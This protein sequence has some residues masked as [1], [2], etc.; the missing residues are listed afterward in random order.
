MSIWVSSFFS[1]EFSSSYVCCLASLSDSAFLTFASSSVSCF[2]LVN[3]S[4]TSFLVR[5]CLSENSAFWSANFSER[6]CWSVISLFS[7]IWSDHSRRPFDRASSDWF[8][9]S[10]PSTVWMSEG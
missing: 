3:F 6:S 2:S 7:Y 9:A 8:R 10:S 5:D 4:S 1:F